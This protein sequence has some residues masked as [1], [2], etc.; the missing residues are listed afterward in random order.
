M[1]N[2]FKEAILAGMVLAGL[3]FVICALFIA[4]SET[5]R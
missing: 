4:L 3:A 1:K 5:F 2:A